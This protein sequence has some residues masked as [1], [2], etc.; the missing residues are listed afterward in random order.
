VTTAAAPVTAIV[1]A[2]GRSRRFG[3][4][5]LAEPVGGRPLVQRAIE[6]VA[7]VASDVVVVGPG[8]GTVRGTSGV[9]HVPD[10][11]P[12][13]GPLVA[14]AAGLEIAAQPLALVVGGDMP[15]L[16]EAV[17]RALLR[18][19]T[20]DE[21]VDAVCLVHR[22]RRQPLPMAVRV[23]AAT[24]AA[25]KLVGGGERRLQA[26]PESLLAR[27]LAEGDWRALDPEAA[28]LRDVDRPEDLEGLA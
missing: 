1:L 16:A 18:P 17:L 25:R 9:R 14:V 8:H 15:T 6:A 21:G 20:T 10:P 22:G 27:D 12:F 23:G 28:T 19:L 2:G 7:R 3:R 13:A 4:D 5:K 26:L 11:E 24:S